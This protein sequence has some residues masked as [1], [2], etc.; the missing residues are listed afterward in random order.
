M[1]KIETKRLLLRHITIEDATDIYDYSREP[2]VGPYAGW[3]PHN[4]IDETHQIM[5]ELFI[6]HDNIFGIVIKG[7]NK[8]I[9]TIG[10]IEDP[11]RQN[12]HALMLGYAMS[13]K[14]WGKGLMTEA[15]K[16]VI[17]HAFCELPI[18]IISC[19]CYPHNIGSRRVI[20][21]C[22]FEY[23]GCLKQAE[24]RYDGAIMNLQCYSLL[25]KQ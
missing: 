8:V 2:N 25:R 23:E 11:R 1:K 7:T 16:A 14:Y 6:E 3:K 19:T 20:E 17:E 10:L 9:G 13:E 5:N 24:E 18:N 4:N 15:A 12:S 21:K 22:G